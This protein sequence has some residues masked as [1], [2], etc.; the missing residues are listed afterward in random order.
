VTAERILALVGL[1]LALLLLSR[2]AP[3]AVRSWR[4]YAGVRRRRLADA[5][6]LE[7]PPPTPVAE[8]LEELRALGFTR[9]GERFL[10][11]PGAPVRYEW[12]VRDETG[13]TFVAVVPLLASALVVCYSSFEDGTWVQTNFPRGE[14]IERRGFLAGFVTTS[15]ADAVATHRRQVERLGPAHGTIR[16]VMTMADSLRM[17][18]DFRTRFGGTTLRP[19]TL[20]LI[21]PGITAAALAVICALLLL[22]GR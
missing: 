5:G 18:A 21:M 22:L 2:F 10:R 8:R 9:L 14:V 17:D 15:V 6:P 12:N 20:R 3:V 13:D 11:L 19:I 4:I 1:V 7:I 16:P